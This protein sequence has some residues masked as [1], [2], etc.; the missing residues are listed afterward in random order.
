ML[1]NWKIVRAMVWETRPTGAPVLCLFS[2]ENSDAT[3]IADKRP[4]CCTAACRF[5]S[6]SGAD[7]APLL[8]RHACKNFVSS[9]SKTVLARLSEAAF[10]ALM[11]LA[12]WDPLKDC[13]L[14]AV[15]SAPSRTRW[16]F[17]PLPCSLVASFITRS[18]EDSLWTA[19]AP[20]AV[21][22]ETAFSVRPLRNER[23]T[24]PWAGD[25]RSTEN[26]SLIHI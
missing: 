26:L 4:R 24:L 11:V 19:Q 2:R 22:I 17:L 12:L 20:Q 21:P 3:H 10:P 8:N 25:T 7:S 15:K 6:L 14:L 5:K 13:R 9:S 1:M 23:R 18:C 16:R